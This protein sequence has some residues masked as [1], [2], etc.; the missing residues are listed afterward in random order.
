MAIFSTKKQNHN[1]FNPKEFNRKQ[2][3]QQNLIFVISAI[4]IIIGLVAMVIYTINF[5]IG[6]MDD[7]FATIKN[8]VNLEGFD[9]EGFGKIKDKVQIRDEEQLEKIIAQ[10]IAENPGPLAQYREGKTKTFG[11]FVGQVMKA[12]QGRANPELV[13]ECLKKMLNRGNT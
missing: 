13:N 2:L 11:F 10:V 4:I 12:T 6:Q 7:I 5:I 9:V 1:V 3:Q 8:D